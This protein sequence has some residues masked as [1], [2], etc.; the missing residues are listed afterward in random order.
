MK[1]VVPMVLSGLIA[2]HAAGAAA[3]ADPEKLRALDN[4]YKA[5]VL[6]KDE[7]EAKKRALLAAR[8]A[9]PPAT[10]NAP[11]RSAAAPAAVPAKGVYRMRLVRVMD[12]QGF[13][14]PVEVLRM[15]IP[16]DWR[17]EDQV[18][19]DGSQSG[20]PA[21]IIQVRF[22][23]V[24]PDG[25]TGLEAFPSYA[26]TWTDDP[27]MQSILRQQAA[28]RTGCAPYPAMGAADFIRNMAVPGLRAGAQ[29]RDVEPLPGVAQAEQRVAE[30]N[31]RPLIQAGYVR[32]VRVDAA[33]VRL[34]YSVG[35]RPVEEWMA[36]TVST[37]I[38][39]AASTA[40]LM[41]G[42]MNYNSS[43]Y[44][45]GAYNVF[46][47][48]APR[49][50]LAGRANLFGMIVSS[51]RINPQYL[52]AAA[53]FIAS[54]NKIN[55]DGAKDRHRIW[56]EANASIQKTWQETRRNQ[57]EVQDRQAEQF[58]QMIRGVENYVDPRTNERI[59]LSAGYRNAWTNGK[60]EYLLSET[61]GF[62]PAATF[63]E[64]WRELKRE[65]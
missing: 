48:R 1:A 46:G 17:F 40:E 3:Q 18:N 33:R 50:E 58:G 41:Q 32:G 2:L 21:N 34:E 27:M 39:P 13:G 49:G 25:I 28:N 9:N 44:S 55:T 26:W 61:P 8:P 7:Y 19:W 42:N 43:N 62:D 12:K 29:P 54:I 37:S 5:G 31:A 6:D 53:N 59:E 65:R 11:Q 22:R 24:A 60:G 14:E 4:A 35:N 56:Q 57:Q 10:A 45:V 63:R 64:D 23:A 51:V 20:C 30:N 36:A 15:L 52:A 16:A 47:V 38:T